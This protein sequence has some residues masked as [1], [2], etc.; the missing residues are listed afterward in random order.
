[1][2]VKNL[3]GDEFIYATKTDSYG[4]VDINIRINDPAAAN[5]RW[6]HQFRQEYERE[7]QLRTTNP[8]VAAA[9]EQYQVAVNLCKD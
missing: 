2:T 1:M 7:K 5:L 4:G 8:T 3:F 9:W 6:L